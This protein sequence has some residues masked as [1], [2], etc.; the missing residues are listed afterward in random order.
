MNIFNETL[1]VNK[2]KCTDSKKMDIYVNILAIFMLIIIL[3]DIIIKNE[4]LT[5]TLFCMW[6]FFLMFIL[7]KD[8]NKSNNNKT[9]INPSNPLSKLYPIN[10]QVCLV[11]ISLWKIYN[12]TQNQNHS[13]SLDKEKINKINSLFEKLDN[14]LMSMLTGQ[15]KQT[16]NLLNLEDIDSYTKLYMLIIAPV[17]VKHLQSKI[18]DLHQ[19]F[20]D[21]KSFYLLEQLE[22]T[23][24]EIDEKSLNENYYFDYKE[25]YNNIEDWL[26]NINDEK[27]LDEAAK[28]NYKQMIKDINK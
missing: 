5:L 16:L 24:K 11:L 23:A 14:Q 21:N 6:I 26:K 4:Q 10:K 13:V 3:L 18:Q 19:K 2:I 7:Y 28:Q 8:I 27:Y 22:K 25:W 20:T 12:I 15:D 9:T 17:E 1:E